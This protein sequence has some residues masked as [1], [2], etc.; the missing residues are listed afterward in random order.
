MAAARG[1]GREEGR[2]HR[3]SPPHARPFPPLPFPALPDLN[4]AHTQ[5]EY[6]HAK[7]MYDTAGMPNKH[8]VY[9]SM[10]SAAVILGFGIPLYAVSFSQ[11]KTMG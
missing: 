6:L 3:G 8:L 5:Q 4:R 10:V 7:K 2:A 9:G 1:G 11:S